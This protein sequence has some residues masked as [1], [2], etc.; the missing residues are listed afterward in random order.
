M[1]KLDLEMV[2]EPE[3]KFPASI[4]LLKNNR[5][6]EKHLLL[7][8]TPKPLAMWVTTLWKILQEMVIPDHLTCLLRN[9]YS[10]QEAIVRTKRGTIDG[11]QIGKGVCQGWYIVTLFI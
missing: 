8:T 5:V 2:E 11:L 1:Y 10:G 9:L 6:P 3:I 7:L 4:G